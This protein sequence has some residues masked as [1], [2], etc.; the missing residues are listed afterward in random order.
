MIYSSTSATHIEISTCDHADFFLRLVDQLRQEVAVL[1]ENLD[2]SIVDEESNDL[3]SPSTS[4]D[5]GALQKVPLQ[6]IM[7]ICKS[8]PTFCMIL[9]LT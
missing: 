4:T 7:N 2:R 5:V 8:E 6:T 3:P 1:E 9:I